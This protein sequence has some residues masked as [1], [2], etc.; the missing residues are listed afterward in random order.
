MVEDSF[1]GYINEKP[2]PIES[3]KS[4][5]KDEKS[6]SEKRKEWNDNLFDKSGNILVSK[7]NHTFWKV[8]G[9]LFIVSL[10]SV[11]IIFLYLVEKGKIQS[12]Y[13]LTINPMFNATVNNA[14]DFKP[15]T[16]NNIY[17]NNTINIPKEI[18][19]KLNINNQT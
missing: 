8:L 12:I 18:A 11:S 7:G 4:Y 14:Y 9:I 16:T 2:E 15:Q 5:F 1:S 17:I 3:D 10:L 19:I 13:D 6:E